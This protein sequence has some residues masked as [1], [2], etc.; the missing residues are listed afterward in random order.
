MG[1]QNVTELRHLKL[2]S[3]EVAEYLAFYINCSN[4]RKWPN[5]H[6]CGRGKEK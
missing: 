4:T 6:G 2:I 5:E 3:A 1:S